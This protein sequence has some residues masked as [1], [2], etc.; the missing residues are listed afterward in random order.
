MYFILHLSAEYAPTPSSP[1][2]EC[3]KNINRQERNTD[4]K[5]T[6]HQLRGVCKDH[7]FLRRS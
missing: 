4:Q 5:K 7:Y 1:P 3:L 2:C 6:G